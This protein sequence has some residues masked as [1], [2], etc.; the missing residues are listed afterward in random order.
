MSCVAR[1]SAAVAGV[2]V[3]LSCIISHFSLFFFLPSSLF[4]SFSTPPF[5]IF[6]SSIDC[7]FLFLLAIVC[8]YTRDP[9]YPLIRAHAACV[10][11][12][13]GVSFKSTSIQAPLWAILARFLH[14]LHSMKLGINEI[15]KCS[16]SLVL[17][18]FL[19]LRFLAPDWSSFH[20]PTS[21]PRFYHA[22]IPSSH[23]A[24]PRNAL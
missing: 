16:F 23:P 5:H 12:T 21:H 1:L 13:R 15:S 3:T 20:L 19:R 8:L 11:I 4:S 14:F 6:T 22:L 10:N 17:V 18:V 9:I 24:P 2:V 7:I